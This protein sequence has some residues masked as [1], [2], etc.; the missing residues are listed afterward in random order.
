MEHVQIEGSLFNSFWTLERLAQP[1]PHKET[2]A[3]ELRLKV[4]GIPVSPFLEQCTVG[5]YLWRKTTSIHMKHGGECPHRLQMLSAFS[6]Q[7][8]CLYQSE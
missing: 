8:T 5:H 1:F 4:T 6:L 7:Q 2:L 3:L